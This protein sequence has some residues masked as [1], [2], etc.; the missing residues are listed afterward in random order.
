MAS[1]SRQSR[2]RLFSEFPQD[3]VAKLRRT[4]ERVS[5]AH[6]LFEFGEDA[7]D[8]FFPH[9]GTVVSLVRTSMDGGEVEVGIVGGDGF[10][11]IHS[12]LA[13][14]SYRA[15]AIVQA[16]GV[17][18]RVS[19]AALRE[20]AA[21]DA[22]A[23]TLLLAYVAAHMEQV[24]QNALCNGIHTI[25]QRLAKWLLIMRDRVGADT[26]QLTHEFLAQMLG[27]RRSGVTVAVGALTDYGL[28]EH[29]RNKIV[30]LKPSAIQSRACDCYTAIASVFEAFD[31]HLRNPG[32]AKS[33]G[34]RGPSAQ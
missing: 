22:P 11:E 6:V 18:T 2:N 32:S 7:K 21:A 27:I 12:F 28:I 1:P 29:S 15:R 17:V 14:S 31:A 34:D 13:S 33:D 25:E 24:T 9:Q 16:A 8:A 23:R 5:L 19:L 20:L 3:A 30:L 4:E 10:T 26:L